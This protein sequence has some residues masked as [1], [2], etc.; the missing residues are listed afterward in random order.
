MKKIILSILVILSSYNLYS[1]DKAIYNNLQ[2]SL[3]NGL[4]DIEKMP[5]GNPSREFLS[6]PMN[7]HEFYDSNIPS[8]WRL[9]TKAEFLQ[10]LRI[11]SRLV[12]EPDLY[13]GWFEFMSV[14]ACEN[15]IPFHFRIYTES[16]VCSMMG[17]YRQG[18]E[19]KASYLVKEGVITIGHSRPVEGEIK[20]GFYYDLLFGEK[21]VQFV[22]DE[23]SEFKPTFDKRGYI[24]LVRD[25]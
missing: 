14:V 8:G 10:M 7:H 22:I 25:L 11:G 6:I 2:W 3:R 16:S 21:S 19:C 1:Q 5:D 17:G 15:H 4:T 9:P 23:Y 24:R 18:I 13:Y 20:R 12:A